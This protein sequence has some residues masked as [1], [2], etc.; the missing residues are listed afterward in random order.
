MRLAERTP[1]FCAGCYGQYPALRHVDYESAWDGPM[2][3]AEDGIRM[4]VDEL[5][6]CEECI[7]AGARLVGMSDA[8]DVQENEQLRA[9]VGE[10]RRYRAENE[11]AK[12]R[13][14]KALEV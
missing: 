10:L 7:K 3:N 9:E 6:M 8:L 12:T 5:V 14:R 1:P 11:R 4:T 2:L 13:A